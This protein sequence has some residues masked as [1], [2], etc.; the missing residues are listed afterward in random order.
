MA[1]FPALLYISLGDDSTDIVCQEDTGPLGVDDSTFS[2]R[3][4]ASVLFMRTVG[5]GCCLGGANGLQLGLNRMI[6]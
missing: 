6:I 2:F 3:M 1:V 5:F 4:A